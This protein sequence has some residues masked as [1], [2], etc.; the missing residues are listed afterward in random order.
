MSIEKLKIIDAGDNELSLP[1]GFNIKAEPVGRRTSVLEVAYSHGGRD[2]S[3]G[4]FTP[5]RVEIAGKLWAHSDDDFNEKWDSLAFILVQENIRIKYRGRLI[6]AVRAEDISL[7]YP[8]QVGFHFGE[9]VVSYLCVDPFW[10][11]LQTKTVDVSTG[12]TSP[13]NINL[14]PLGNIEVF[15]EIKITS[16]DDNASFSLRNVTDGEREFTFEDAGVGDGS[17]VEINCKTGEVALDGDSAI[18]SFSGMFLRLLPGRENTLRYTGAEAKIEIF[19][20]EAWL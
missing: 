11:A 3:D 19:Y 5:R 9:V 10:Y 12:G 14:T 6:H 1:R 8:S 20:R 4:C 2:L 18:A 7:V 17:I 15:P 16:Y 13:Y